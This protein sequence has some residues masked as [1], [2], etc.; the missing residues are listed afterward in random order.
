MA[1]TKNTAAKVTDTSGRSM[2]PDTLSDLVTA[3]MEMEYQD[4]KAAGQLGFQA[5]A[6]TIT[7][8]PHS[9]LVGPDGRELRE[10]TRRNGRHNLTVQAGPEAVPGTGIAYGIMPRLATIYLASQAKKTNSREIELGRSMA[11]FLRRLN[12]EGTGGKRG[13]YTRAHTQLMRWFTSSVMAWES[14]V[15]GMEWESFRM[16][17]HGAIMWN[18]LNPEQESLWESTLIL[19][20][21]AFDEMT[22]RAVPVDMRGLIDPTIHRSP[23]AMDLY[24]WLPYRAFTVTVSGKTARIPWQLL[25][26]QF[27]AGYAQT[28]QG[29]RHFRAEARK[30]IKI[31]LNY[32][33]NLRVDASGKDALV[34]EPS[35]KTLRS[36]D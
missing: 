33:S 2:T 16:V 6:L 17:E 10:Y 18:P 29:I 23:L 24:T 31:I 19:S 35:L 7:T 26:V 25:M 34:I 15:A 8:L 5:H 13:G 28:A 14:G 32:Y 22:Q 21:R 12:V 30:A 3:A 27:G 20:P 1:R 4:A 9:R 11:E 36:E